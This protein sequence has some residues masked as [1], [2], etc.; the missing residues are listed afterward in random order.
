MATNLPFNLLS[1]AQS[2]IGVQDIIVKRFLS[3]SANES[4]DLVSTYENPIEVSVSVQPVT[5]SMYS[6]MGLDFE[7][8]YIS[9]LSTED[10]MDLSRDRSGDVVEFGGNI[11]ETT[12]KTDW[13]KSAGWV[14]VICVKVGDVS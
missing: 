5:R 4:G 7:K 1:A 2:A 3:R 14:R 10:V 8:T 9:I 11:Y 13:S 6:K 12:G